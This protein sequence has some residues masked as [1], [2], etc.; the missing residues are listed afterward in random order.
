MSVMAVA[1][2]NSKG[3]LAAIRVI[4]EDIAYLS[5]IPQELHGAEGI[6]RAHIERLNAEKGWLLDH[7]RHDAPG[8]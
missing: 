5:S 8:S 1:G 3:R 2:V 6:M 4:D 7:T